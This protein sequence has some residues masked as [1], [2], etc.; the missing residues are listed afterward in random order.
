MFMASSARA[1]PGLYD[2]AFPEVHVVS[3]PM[4]DAHSTRG[5]SLPDT[6][7]TARSKVAPKLLVFQ[8]Q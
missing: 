4:S 7:S 5:A 6:K 2:C 8:H 1:L 3:P